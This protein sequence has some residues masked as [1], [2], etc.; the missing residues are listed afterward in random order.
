MINLALNDEDPG[1]HMP[2]QNSKTKK[3]MNRT[4]VFV[5]N[6]GMINATNENVKIRLRIVSK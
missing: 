3:H 2:T 5:T 1:H 6:A 4:R